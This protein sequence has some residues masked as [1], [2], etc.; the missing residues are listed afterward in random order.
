MCVCEGCTCSYVIGQCNQDLVEEASGRMYRS[1]ECEH[2]QHSSRKQC[3]LRYISCDWGL[4]GVKFR[5]NKGDKLVAW[6]WWLHASSFPGSLQQ[7]SVSTLHN[8][9]VTTFH[10]VVSEGSHCK[11]TITTL[12]GSRGTC[13]ECESVKEKK[14]SREGQ[15]EDSDPIFL[16]EAYQLSSTTT[17]WVTKMSS[18]IMKWSSKKDRSFDLVSRGLEWQQAPRSPFA[19]CVLV[20]KCVWSCPGEKLFLAHFLGWRALKVSLFEYPCGKKQQEEEEETKNT[21]NISFDDG[22]HAR[23]PSSCFCSHFSSSWRCK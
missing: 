7:Y 19:T 21:E 15:T 20:L 6:V 4:T 1:R 13:W 22:G 17:S 23:N 18:L 16:E 2:E 12:F 10:F 8:E 11:F 9:R 14:F 3:D 5:D